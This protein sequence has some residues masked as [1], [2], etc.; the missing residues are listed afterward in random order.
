M[1]KTELEQLIYAARFAEKA[2]LELEAYMDAFPQEYEQHTGH[3]PHGRDATKADSG[4]FHEVGEFFEQ[5]K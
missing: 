3:K 1:T 5:T 4:F 2:E